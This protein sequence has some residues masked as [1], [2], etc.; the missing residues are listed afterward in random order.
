MMQQGGS[1]RNHQLALMSM[2]MSTRC[3]SG[4]WEALLT[5]EDNVSLPK[6]TGM[7]FQMQQLNGQ[8]RPEA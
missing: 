6:L 4:F 5:A 8:N 7:P 3:L 1:L 2:I